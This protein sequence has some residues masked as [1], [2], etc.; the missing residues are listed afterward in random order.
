MG[1]GKLGE[2]SIT[3]YTG[4]NSGLSI[5]HINQYGYLFEKAKYCLI[6]TEISEMIVEY[7]MKFCRENGTQVILKPAMTG[8]LREELYPY[9]TYLVPN[10]KELHG[11]LPGDGTIEEKAQI[12]K[13]KG[14]KNVIVTL[15]AIGEDDKGQKASAIAVTRKG[16]QTSIPTLEEVI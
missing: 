7:T 1:V 3:V 9:I 15:G 8:V 16:A 10:E 2:S 6:S 5:N 11:L 14:V 4:A 13:E 12:L